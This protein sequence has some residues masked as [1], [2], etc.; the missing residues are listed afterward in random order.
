MKIVKDSREFTGLYTSLVV[1]TDWTGKTFVY[2]HGGPGSHCGDFETGLE[3]FE[4]FTAQGTGWLVYDQRGCGRSNPS[5]AR[6]LSH[7]HNIDDL[8]ELLASAKELYQMPKMTL[9]LYGHSYG[10]RLVY[11]LLATNP[12]LQTTAV[13]SGRSLHP[14]DAMNTSVL[15]DMMILRNSD[16]SSFKK[17][18]TILE[19]HSAEPYE[20]AKD[21]R[22]CFKNPEERQASRQ[23]FYWAN[24]NAKT[25]WDSTVKKL[26]LK[27]SDEIYFQVAATYGN[28]AFNSGVFDPSLL[29]QRCLLIQ[30]FYDVLMY[31]T[32]NPRVQDS[33]RVIRFNASAHYPHFEQPELFMKTILAFSNGEKQ[34]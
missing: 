2:V 9:C 28:E 3:Q 20:I 13:I 14:F 33:S 32:A 1:P 26:P 16:M 15:I 18:L 10:A 25:W 23:Q 12:S 17:A 4:A 24:E 5:E 30:G 6:R 11:D 22:E 31:G 19:S 21:I 8:A 7:R 34:S 29:R 27:D